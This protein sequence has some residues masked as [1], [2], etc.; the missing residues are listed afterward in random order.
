MNSTTG[1]GK[2][3]LERQVLQGKDAVV[4]TKAMACAAEGGQCAVWEEYYPDRLS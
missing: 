4:I 2:N 1:K 3:D